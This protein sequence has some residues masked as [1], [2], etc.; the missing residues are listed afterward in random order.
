MKRWLAL[1][2]LLTAWALGALAWAYLRPAEA[3]QVTAAAPVK[4]EL[5]KEAM[6][7]LGLTGRYPEQL[8]QAYQQHG[9]VLPARGEE[10][11]VV[12]NAAPQVG[13]IAVFDQSGKL[14]GKLTELGGI[15]SVSL[16]RLPG[17]RQQA[18]VVAEHADQMLGA[19]TVTDWLRIYVWRN[20]AFAEVW[21]GVRSSRSFVNEAWEGVTRDPGWMRTAVD[22]EITFEQRDRAF[23]IRLKSREVKARSTGQAVPQPE[24]RWTTLA[25]RTTEQLWVWQ[26]GGFKLVAEGAR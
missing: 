7:K 9:D 4:A 3:V 13:A 25:T 26:R 22:G 21:K 1:N 2:L 23:Y 19:Y 20:S 17:L 12:L 16:I 24:R 15:T 6:D 8:L 10:T 14:A 5:V 11:I 18:L